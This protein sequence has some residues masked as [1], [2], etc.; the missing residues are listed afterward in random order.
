MRVQATDAKLQASHSHNT[1]GVACPSPHQTFLNVKSNMNALTMAAHWSQFKL[2]MEMNT[3][4]GHAKSML[5]VTMSTLQILKIQIQELFAIPQ[6]VIVAF[7]RNHFAAW[8]PM[9]GQTCLLVDL[10]FK[11]LE[12]KLMFFCSFLKFVLVLKFWLVLLFNLVNHL[13]SLL[14]TVLHIFNKLLVGQQQSWA[15]LL[16]VVNLKWSLD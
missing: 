1:N 6:Q 8:I 14:M 13:S 7:A 15:I 3:L 10:E 4:A 9:Q 5:N 12:F 11:W 16:V 2:L